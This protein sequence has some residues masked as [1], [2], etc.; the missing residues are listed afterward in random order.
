MSQTL[1]EVNSQKGVSDLTIKVRQKFIQ[2]IRAE[3]D[4]NGSW[5]DDTH[6]WTNSECEQL[7]NEAVALEQAWR[8]E[9]RRLLGAS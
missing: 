5:D 4:S 3:Q 1:K 2:A 6:T 9:Q 8:D 7:L